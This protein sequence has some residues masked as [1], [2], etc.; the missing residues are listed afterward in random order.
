M[1]EKLIGRDCPVRNVTTGK[2]Y[3]NIHYA[4]MDLGIQPKTLYKYMSM[5]QSVNGH[6]FERIEMTERMTDR[7]LRLNP[8][9]AQKLNMVKF[10][11]T[12]EVGHYLA[13]HGDKVLVYGSLSSVAS[14]CDLSG[15][16][17]CRLAK[18]G[19]KDAYGRIWIKVQNETTLFQLMGGN[20][21]EVNEI[22]AKE[23]SKIKM[24][25]AR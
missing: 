21:E 12:L 10:P 6:R 18:T 17:I 4:C 5:G 14:R 9:F 25:A 19:Q 24:P 2:V 20:L 23:V 7:K 3:R 22:R 13:V 15:V 16:N 11:P 1:T 8:E